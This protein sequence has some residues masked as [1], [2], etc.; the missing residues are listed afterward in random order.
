MT[1]LNLISFSLLPFLFHAASSQFVSPPTDLIQTSGY[2]NYSV[3]Y[4]EVPDGIC[5][6]TPGVKS[7]SGYVDIAKNQHIFWWLFEARN[8][9]PTTAP[10]TI[11]VRQTN[12]RPT[13]YIWGVRRQERRGSLIHISRYSD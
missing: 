5:E 10:L 3:R 4:K 8:Q 7:Y 12:E 2:L 13:H 1:L 6:T 9:D 11:W